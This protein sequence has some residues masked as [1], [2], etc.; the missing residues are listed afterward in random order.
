MS[1]STAPQATA[2]LNN[3]SPSRDQ[4]SAAR[5]ATRTQFLLLGL[6]GGAWG[7]HIPSVKLR[8]GL[9]EMQLSL[10]LLAAA[11][12]ALL[13][14][15]L[16]GRLIGRYGH[17]P[18]LAGAAMVIGTLLGLSL[19]WPSLA[20][21]L[22]AMVLFGASSGIYDVAINAEGTALESLSGRA[23]MGGLH[24]MFSVGGMSGAALA[25]AL[26]R[27]GMPAPWQLMLVGALV[28][29]LSVLATRRM[30]RQH[31]QGQDGD[32]ATAH[33]AWPRGRLLLIGLLIFAGMTA[34]GVMYDWSVLY[35]KQELAMPQA[36]AGLGFAVFSAAMAVT[37]LT[38]DALRERMAEPRLL[39]GGA[40]LT[41]A[42]MATLLLLA[43]PWPALAG[44]VL[45][46]AGLALVVPILYN[47]ATRVPGVSRAAAIASVSSIGYA[48]FLIGPPLI[49][50]VAEYSSL[51]SAM[52]LVVVA[53]AL[54]AMAAR[55]IG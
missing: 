45:V 29:G 22:P 9:S 33:F 41:A 49:G 15:L 10:V 27:A 53:A 17:R 43:Q 3:L 16:A 44:F 35:L 46:G 6:I 48:G 24:G 51:S 55:R 50:A 36:Q 20:W 14:L 52:W 11:V 37:R 47:A 54:L 5:R 13:S 30:L 8:Y 12:G 34:E 23:V 42:S 39:R 25:A 38:G 1:S 4:L 26:L 28:A 31:P 40:L 2:R 32:A 7:V 21:L 19:Y 18:V